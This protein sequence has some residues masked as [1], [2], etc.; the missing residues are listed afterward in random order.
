M[1]SGKRTFGDGS[2]APID[3]GG[4]KRLSHKGKRRRQQDG[5]SVDEIP[6]ELQ[7]LLDSRLEAYGNLL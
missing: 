3:M 2:V 5:D 1:C 7:R 6:A 4:L